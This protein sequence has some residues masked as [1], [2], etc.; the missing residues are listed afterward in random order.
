MEQTT[1][2]ARSF[3]EDF[4]PASECIRRVNLSLL[5]SQT[6]RPPSRTSAA[7]A[8]LCGGHEL[9]LTLFP[10]GRGLRRPLPPTPGSHWRIAQGPGPD[11]AR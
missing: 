9:A 10:R 8:T 2:Y 11:S 3:P 6:A 7:A 1:T 5:M 4:T